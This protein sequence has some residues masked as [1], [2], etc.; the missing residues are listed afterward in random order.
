MKVD[1]L[2]VL[3]CEEKQNMFFI[4]NII[5]I[6]LLFCNLTVCRVVQ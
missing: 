3:F 1:I 6:I 2:T 4:Y 5:I